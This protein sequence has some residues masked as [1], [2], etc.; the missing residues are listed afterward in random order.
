MKGKMTDEVKKLY[1]EKL[2]P[3]ILREQ[4]NGFAMESWTQGVKPGNNLEFDGVLHDFPQC[5]TVCCIGGS[6]EI[7][8]CR[9]LTKLEASD[10]LGLS[11]QER[12]GLFYCWT[13][14]DRGRGYRWPDEFID[15][16]EEAS[17]PLEK[18]HVAVDLLREVVRTEGEC[19]HHPISPVIF[20]FSE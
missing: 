4:G 7:I 19:L 11:D 6:L 17:T 14:S 15:R 18:A 20:P 1:E 9:F 3:F 5:G 12:Y 10:L 13:S 16:F 2:I 8:K